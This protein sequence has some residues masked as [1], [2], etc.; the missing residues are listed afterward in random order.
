MIPPDLLD[1]PGAGNSPAT[2]SRCCERWSV[3]LLDIGLAS[4]LVPDLLSQEKSL[5]RDDL[6]FILFSFRKAAIKKRAQGTA[7]RL[8]HNSIQLRWF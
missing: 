2:T 8:S 1:F 6:S 4:Y 5:D 7:R 3:F